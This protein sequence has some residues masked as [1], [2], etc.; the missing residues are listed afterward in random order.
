MHWDDAAGTLTFGARE[1]SFPG[2]LEKHTF[3]VVV[4][5][6]G[7]GAGIGNATQTRAVEYKG[8]RVALKP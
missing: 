5:G 8:E 7:R 1:G 2:M 4:V 6:E 3:N